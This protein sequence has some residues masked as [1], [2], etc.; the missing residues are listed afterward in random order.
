MDGR[1]RRRT[2][3]QPG[4]PRAGAAEQAVRATGAP[5]PDPRESHAC[6]GAQAG[7]S[8]RSPARACTAIPGD[9]VRHRPR[10]DVAAVAPAR[11]ARRRARPAAAGGLLPGAAPVRRQRLTRTAHAAGAPASADPGRARRPGCQLL[12]AA[13]SPR[14]RAR[15]RAAP[16]ADDRRAADA[17]ARRSRTRASRRVDLEV[18]ASQVL[19]ARGVRA[20]GSRSRCPRVAGHGTDHGRSTTPRASHCQPDRQRDPPQRPRRTCGDQHRYPGSP[21]LPVHREQRPGDPARRAPAPLPTVPAA[22]RHPHPAPRRIRAGAL[23][24]PSDRHGTPRRPQHPRARAGGA[25]RWQSRSRR[26]A[27]PAPGQR[28]PL[29]GRNAAAR[30]SLRHR[31]SHEPWGGD[32]PLWDIRRVA[33]ISRIAATWTRWATSSR[34]VPPRQEPR[35]PGNASCSRARPQSP[36]SGCR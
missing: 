13:H 4:S 19:L 14:A 24:R 32:R 22:E 15:I 21:R 25:S 9:R 17:H 3:R 29:P 27:A 31:R 5:R 7:R 28:S 18:L 6:R 16:G 23:D 36:G 34:W 2:R 10:G 8:G 12:V 30:A 33:P 1:D 11:L 35:S 20:R 26:R